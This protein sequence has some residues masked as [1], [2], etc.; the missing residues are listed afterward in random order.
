M[1]ILQ[2]GISQTIRH[3]SLKPL[4]SAQRRLP[5]F[6]LPT[7]TQNFFLS[8]SHLRQRLEALQEERRIFVTLPIFYFSNN[9]LIWKQVEAFGTD[10][11]QNCQ[12][13]DL[14]RRNEPKQVLS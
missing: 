2:L 1:V 11:M 12:K 3:D 6:R 13:G 7:T 5:R 14:R 8:I 9:D 10:V 4:R